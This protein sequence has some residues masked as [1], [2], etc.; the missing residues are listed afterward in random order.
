MAPTMKDVARRAGVSVKSVSR[1]VNGDP[2]T[3]GDIQDRVR[4]AVAELGWR[5]NPHARSLRTGRTG[6]VALSVRDL[7][8][9]AVAR[10][11]QALVSEAERDGLHVSIE[12]THGHVERVHQ[13]VE[14]IG[15]LF[16]AAL[17]VHPRAHEVADLAPRYEYPG[18]IICTSGRGHR[19]GTEHEDQP[20]LNADLVLTD[21]DSTVRALARHLRSVGRRRVVALAPPNGSADRLARNLASAG[22]VAMLL[23]PPGPIDRAAGRALAEKALVEVPDL[24][25]IACADDLL[26]IGA[27]SF[28][29]DRGIDVPDTVAVT[30]YGDI[31]DGRFTTPS[32]TSLDPRDDQ[33][34]RLVF[35]LVRRRRA[36]DDGPAN[37]S[38]ISP[39][40]VRR[41]STLGAS[42][43]R[44]PIEAQP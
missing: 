1:V 8:N 20:T 11:A 17:L 41:E 32:L 13:T 18:V 35:D 33:V 12:P 38:L 9:P 19:A 14:A 7:R 26:A 44:L 6:M 22:D 37:V 43:H 40:L 23:R 10:L 15:A 21:L 24:D 28:L 31:E 4:R 29:L 36:G 30:G 34:A 16:D 27:L 42:P 3:S 25:A 5:P 39:H 2:G